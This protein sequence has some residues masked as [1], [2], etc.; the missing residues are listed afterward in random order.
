MTRF[1][2][3]RKRKDWDGE[4]SIASSETADETPHLFHRQSSASPKTQ[5]EYAQSRDSQSEAGSVSLE[6]GSTKKKH[7]DS[8]SLAAAFSAVAGDSSVMSLM[9]TK[10]PV[11]PKD[12]EPPKT[13]EKPETKTPWKR[14]K[15]FDSP[16]PRYRHASSSV[17]SDKNEI[18]LMGGLKEGSVFGDTWKLM[19]Q[20]SP[21]GKEITAI[22]A[23]RVEVPHSNTPPAR[24][25]HASVL[26]G[27]AYIIYGGDTVET[28][29]EGF[30][31]DNFY[32][33]NINNC[34]YTVPL[35]ILNKPKGRYGHSL[36]VVSSSSSSSK[37]YLFGG[38]LENTAYNDL[39]CF[40]LTSFKS[41][42]AGWELVEPRDSVK[43]PP[44]TNH[45]MSIYKNKIYVF[46]GVYNNQTASNDVWCFDS[47]SSKW[48]QVPTSGT[49][50]PPVNEHSACVI[51]GTLYIY[52]GNNFGGVI[53]DDLY[54][55]DLQS[56]TWSMLAKVHGV[57]G[58]GARCGHSMTYIPKLHK[59][60]IMGGDKNDFI[61]PQDSNFD[62]YET[63]SGQYIGTMVYELDLVLAN[64]YMNIAQP[65]PITT[66]AV[67]TGSG[68][69]GRGSV[70]SESAASESVVTGLI[71]NDVASNDVSSCSTD[72]I[73]R[74][75][76]TSS[77]CD[78][79]F[80]GGRRSASV[81]IDEYKTPSN[82]LEQ[83]SKSLDP[84][85]TS[86]SATPPRSQLRE[87]KIEIFS[88]E[89]I[90]SS[91]ESINATR[92]LNEIRENYL[93]GR[94]IQSPFFK[95]DDDDAK[96]D[97]LDTQISNFG[98]SFDPEPSVFSGDDES[99]DDAPISSSSKV[100][101][102]DAENAETTPTPEVGTGS[103]VQLHDS[104]QVAPRQ[105]VK[106]KTN[107]YGSHG[108][109]LSPSRFKGGTDNNEVKQMVAQ[110]TAELNQLKESTKR[111]MES[112]TSEIEA[113]EK[114]N[115]DLEIDRETR[116]TLQAQ[117]FKQAL[118]AKDSIIEELKLKVPAQQN[119]DHSGVAS[120]TS[121]HKG[122]TENIRYKLDRLEWKN[123]LVYIQ[124][125]NAQLK[126]KQAHFEPFMNN[127]I[128]ELST[129]QK[130]IK[131]QEDRFAQLST[132]IS[133]ESS[134]K[135]EIA[136]LKHKYESLEIEFNTYRNLN[137]DVFVSD[138]ED[139]KGQTSQ[140][141][142]SKASFLV[143]GSRK[144]TVSDISS[145]LESLVNLWQEASRNADSTVSEASQ[146]NE[147]VKSLQSQIEDLIK[148]SK[149]QQ[150][151]FSDEIKAMKSELQSKIAS[152]KYFEDNYRDA[153]QSVKNTSKALDLTQAEMT[154]QK[155]TIE[156]LSKEN[157]ELKLFK[158]A[159]SVS[160]K[161]LQ[162]SDTVLSNGS[163]FSHFS[164]TSDTE[165]GDEEEKLTAAHYS[166]KLKDLEADLYIMKQD[167]DQL[168]DQVS[169]LKKEL[170]LVNA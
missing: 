120:E 91:E 70:A 128:G 68:Y 40:E 44:L 121:S 94:D 149:T 105:S 160:K 17:P 39:Y 99:T 73:N 58:P 95:S 139:C 28:D 108:A 22:V 167:R 129:L 162:A 34:K 15:V 32:M 67:Y 97:V 89:D 53:Y 80:A 12:P 111:Q 57:N 101:E 118:L 147:L 102:H 10:V 54:C 72:T 3:G 93:E 1:K 45:S 14:H 56:F 122:L 42:N 41:P 23:Q 119:T 159:A 114:K 60:I 155:H 84:L 92:E 63:F 52:G 126:E 98:S 48:S 88:D 154:S 115:N 31:D 21:T 13:P 25:G 110:L 150:T 74:K 156:K 90:S 137:P 142:D 164:A 20:L 36:G 158:R 103:L 144:K 82:S 157:N 141:S 143:N 16:F 8:Y 11:P 35:H 138:E 62:T 145:K 33:C 130:I 66:N 123:K 43:P 24:V 107:N 169:A 163:S 112:A 125:E 168:N 133:T 77:P 166:M 134:L 113:L 86:N 106:Y 148:T 75:A 19:P 81:G 55:L 65:T 9:P 37:L 71:S 5:S 152:L 109:L 61:Y 29:S 85:K 170:Y 64:K 76:T 153:L 51:S 135:K 2:F 38:Q 100:S 140:E 27:N 49:V 79:A 104:A 161:E 116:F 96:S 136:D 83:F 117:N 26:C 7:R 131:A 78:D 69:V 127:Q 47:K 124:N 59:L 50:P 151:D 87:P 18:F 146:D 46:G 6:M 165:D 4:T 30:P 132:Q